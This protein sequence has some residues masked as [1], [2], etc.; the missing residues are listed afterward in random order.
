MHKLRVDPYRSWTDDDLT[1]LYY[2]TISWGLSAFSMLLA[3]PRY[4]ALMTIEPYHMVHG[5]IV[6]MTSAI[7]MPMM[8]HAVWLNIHPEIAWTMNLWPWMCFFMLTSKEWR[9][10]ACAAG[11]SVLFGSALAGYGAHLTKFED[12][13]KAFGL[14]FL[15]YLFVVLHPDLNM[16][17]SNWSLTGPLQVAGS[18][19]ILEMWKAA[20]PGEMSPATEFKLPNLPMMGDDEEEAP[21]FGGGGGGGGEYYY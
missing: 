1:K 2:Y 14:W 9:G 8:A 4:V 19:I 12:L 21:A 6:A 11:Y 5:P 7:T 15:S 18:K 16:G 3:V 20:G 13:K 10:Q 17:Y